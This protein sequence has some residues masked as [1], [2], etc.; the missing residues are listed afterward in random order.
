MAFHL[1]FVF[2]AYV[3][4]D[5]TDKCQVEYKNIC[6]TKAGIRAEATIE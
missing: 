6:P 3:H 1:V 4:D 5:N 2:W